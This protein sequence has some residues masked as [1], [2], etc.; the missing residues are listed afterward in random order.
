MLELKPYVDFINSLGLG[1]KASACYQPE[2]PMEVAYSW[3]DLS[4]SPD[5]ET[6]NKI[7]QMAKKHNLPY[8]ED[9]I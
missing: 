2:T 4:P 8:I 5:K 1:I 6:Y 3:I 9:Y 7:I